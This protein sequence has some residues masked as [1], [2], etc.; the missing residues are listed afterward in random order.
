MEAPPLAGAGPEDSSD[1]LFVLMLKTQRSD[2]RP[3]SG[4]PECM[5]MLSFSPDAMQ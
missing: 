3:D 2:S 4:H 1:Q 5:Y